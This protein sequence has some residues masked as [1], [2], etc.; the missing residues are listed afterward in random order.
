MKTP[1]EQQ[2]DKLTK[3]ITTKL[4]EINNRLIYIEKR[5]KIIDNHLNEE[6][7]EENE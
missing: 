5:L 1:L 7:E 4:R 2:L 3:T 6:L